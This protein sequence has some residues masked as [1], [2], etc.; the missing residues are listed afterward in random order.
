[1]TRAFIDLAL[2][3]FAAHALGDFVFQSDRTVAQKRHLPVLAGHAFTHAV[4]TYGLVGWWTAWWLP[5]IVFAGHGLIDFVK[6]RT[7]G[8]KAP[9]FYADQAAHAI[10]LVGLAAGAAGASPVARW[11]QILGGRYDPLLVVLTG[12]VIAVRAASIVIGFWVQPYLA[13]IGEHARVTGSAQLAIR[14]LP[15]GGRVI[16]QWER[17]LIFILVGAGQL[18]AIGFLIAAKSIF[19]FG[20]LKDRENRLE[21][22]F[23]TIGTLMS[24]GV[25]LAV[26]LATFW[27]ARHL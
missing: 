27:L 21:A 3:L 18:G 4:L 14:G 17:A 13:E 11:A 22:E 19:R 23:I 26:S 25:G 20:E 24:F 8:G 16:G 15:T 9:L 10:F 2:P 7:A 5:A 12:G 1:M 6:V